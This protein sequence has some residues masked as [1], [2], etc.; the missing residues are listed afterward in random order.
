MVVL[1]SLL[2][3][4]D[5]T[6]AVGGDKISLPYSLVC[7]AVTPKVLFE[8]CFLRDPLS[9][10][11][12]YCFAEHDPPFF[13]YGPTC[14]WLFSFS[15]VC[16]K[17][18][19]IWIGPPYLLKVRWTNSGSKGPLFEQVK[20]PLSVLSLHL[21]LFQLLCNP[22]TISATTFSFSSS[23]SMTKYQHSYWTLHHPAKIRMG[24]PALYNRSVVLHYII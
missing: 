17:I 13:K 8:L 10:F 7:S 24:A 11:W 4:S 15:C 9:P 5:L 20:I 16:V 19:F 22:Q 23:L 18:D 12:S 6:C 2:S 1:P 3:D 14:S 21:S